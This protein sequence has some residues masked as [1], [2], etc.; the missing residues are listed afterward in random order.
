MTQG[1]IRR[2]KK[3]DAPSIALL[4]MNVG[5]FTVVT[6]ESNH[7]PKVGLLRVL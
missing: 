7:L 2:K 6:H 1:V 3:V 5:V 4:P